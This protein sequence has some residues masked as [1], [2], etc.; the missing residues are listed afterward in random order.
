MPE[1]KPVRRYSSVRRAAMQIVYYTR[2]VMRLPMMLL[3]GIL[4]AIAGIFA[5]FCFLGFLVTVCGFVIALGSTSGRNGNVGTIVE[6]LVIE[7]FLFLISGGLAWICVNAAFDITTAPRGSLIN[8]MLPE[9]NAVLPDAEVLVRA[10]IASSAAQ[11]DILL[12]PA[13]AKPD[14]EPETLLRA[15]KEE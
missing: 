10:S 13:N 9:V 11:K 2:Q 8:P 12:R 6:W 1:N 3:L 15:A 14:V 5:F 7:A 4:G